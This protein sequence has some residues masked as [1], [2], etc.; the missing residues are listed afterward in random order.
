MKKSLLALALSL[1]IG[2]T[3]NGQ[4]RKTCVTDEVYRETIQKHP[5]LLL[6]QQELEQFT[7]RF[8]QENK[9]QR[10]AGGGIAYV[11]PVVFHII[12]NYGPENISD[13]QVID[14]V[15]VMNLDYSKLN[16]DTTAIVP[17]FQGIA[18]NCQ[19]EFRLANIDPQGNCTNGIDRVV[20]SLTMNADDNAK[21]NPWPYQ[22]YLNI[23]VINTFSSSHSGAA[24]YAY[25]PGAAFPAN[26][27]G[28]IARYDY[29]GSI[30]ASSPNNSRTLTHEAGH[31]L[32]LAHPWGSTNQPGVA[33]G[34]TDNVSD[35][36]ETQGWTSCNL[37]GSVC[38][39]PVIENVQN[40]ME[41]SY[42]DVMFTEGQKARMHAALNSSVGSRNNLWSLGNLTA[43][44]TDG[45]PTQ[46]CIP[47]TDFE[48]D[49]ITVCAGATVNFHDLCWNGDPTSWSWDFPGGTP[50]TSTDSFPAVVYN[51]A[52]TYDVTL[53]ASNSAGSSSFTR[54]AYVRVSGPPSQVIP[55]TESFEVPASFPGTDGYVI[56]PDNGTTWTRVTTAASSGTA[57]IRINNYTNT[58]GQ[59]DQW[60][61]PAFDFSNVTLPTMH[62][63]VANAQ[64]NSG[65]ADELR[66]AGSNNCG[67]TWN[68]RYTKSGA[69]LAT[70]GIVS[71]SF[72]PNASQW[73]QETANLNPFALKPNV[74]F[75]FENT[76]DRGNN[77]YIDSIFITGTFVGL[78]EV[79]EIELGFALY[80]NPSAGKTTVQFLLN[81]AQKVQLDVVDITGRLVSSL[82]N[83]DL[84]AGLHEYTISIQNPGIYFVDLVSGGKRHVRKLIIS[85]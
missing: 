6:Q 82:A 5:E 17:S 31:C 22:N 34:G 26:K 12:H 25:Y 74:R 85:E 52:G 51:T 13:A 75:M 69:T 80:P 48:A 32:N 40:F 84:N 49:E 37:S 42:C 2:W 76:S 83:D 43:T 46:V 79:D 63:T 3:A 59:V 61:T 78:D 62:F 44:G 71:T 45:S 64:R 54:T 28:V 14:A 11:I 70:A 19:I 33:C 53:T 29:V 30:G 68:Y 18:A 55:F 38:N 56:N 50:S 7:S 81:Q 57:S 9:T 1:T 8:V 20:S 35:T 15:R 10:T 39:P 60:I 16:A 66:V 23:W 4:E 21:L 36:P 58:S 65:S 77:T 27:D 67:R 73:R 24:A 47:N 41:Y 72:T